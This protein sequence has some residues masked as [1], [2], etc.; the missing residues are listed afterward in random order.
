MIFSTCEYFVNVV[1]RRSVVNDRTLENAGTLCSGWTIVNVFLAIRPIFFYGSCLQLSYLRLIGPPPR[2]EGVDLGSL[3]MAKDQG[4][5]FR[6][7]PLPERLIPPPASRPNLRIVV[8]SSAGG[9]GTSEPL[10]IILGSSEVPVS[11]LDACTRA[12][13]QVQTVLIWKAHA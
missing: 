10:E 7:Q 2:L 8:V 13:D 12:S 11:P 4:R 6:N 9:F 3:M 1:Y 5:L